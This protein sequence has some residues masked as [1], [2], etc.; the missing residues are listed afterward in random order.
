MGKLIRASINLSKIKKELIFDGKT[1]KHLNLSIW[2]NEE[3]DQY[4]NL[5][6]IQQSTKEGEQ[7]IYLG[8]GNFYEKA[9]PA[10][11]NTPAPAKVEEKDVL[12]DD[13]GLPF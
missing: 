8:N 9:K 13:S 5:V 10:A 11:T 4:G 3:P 1:G 7:K 2:I 12:N 6:S